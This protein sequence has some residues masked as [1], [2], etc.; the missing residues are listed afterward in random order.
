[1]SHTFWMIHVPN[2]KTWDSTY[3]PIP[4]NHNLIPKEKG[5]WL[6]PDVEIDVVFSQN[7]FDAFK[8]LA[9]IAKHFKIPLVS[10]EH[11]LAYPNWHPK[12][13]EHLQSLKGDINVF[14]S[15]FS[16]K[17]WGFDESAEVIEHAI[18]IDIFKPNDSVTKKS[19]ILSI[20][21]D[22]IN[23]D[24][25]C[26][27]KLWQQVTK[28]LPVKVV[29]ATPG[30]SN[31]AKDLNELVKFYRESDVFINSSLLSPIPTALL[32]AMA[33]GCACV[34]TANCLI[35]SIIK[36]GE[37][38]FLS[39]DTNELRGYC[40]ELLKNK[41]LREKLGANAR[42]TIKQ[43]FGLERFTREWED[44]FWRASRIRKD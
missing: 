12:F 8:F 2:G 23:R 37:N 41:D 32:E 44:L 28:D 9:P 25:P 43:R 39:N 10:L 4:K 5:F 18:D 34:S 29:G 33:C 35:P 11:T 27:F 40:I 31:P 30:L 6:P 22:W 38:G 36:N 13:L 26:G 15:D 21:N 14:I 20:V 42:E 1:M 3:R 19:H 17:A 16:R 24:A 7:R